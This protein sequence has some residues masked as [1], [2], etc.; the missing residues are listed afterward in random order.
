MSGTWCGC[1]LVSQHD[2]APNHRFLVAAWLNLFAADCEQLYDCRAGRRAACCMT[3]GSL[4]LCKLMP[5]IHM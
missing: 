5:K 2:L 1:V 4:V 3:S